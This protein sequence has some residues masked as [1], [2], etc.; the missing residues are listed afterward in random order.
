MTVQSTPQLSPALFVSELAAQDATW[1]LGAQTWQRATDAQTGGALGLI[2][3]VIAPGFASPY[4]VHHKEDESF[5]V[6]EGTMRFYSEGCAWDAGAGGFAFLPRDIPHGFRVMGDTPARVLLLMTPGGFE[7]FVA[8]LSEPSP[9]AGPPDMGHLMRVAEK[10]G[11]DI[12]GP[13]PE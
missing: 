2:E 5:Y 1:F 4:H 10:Y 9:P 8:E 11:I 13:L 7:G 6:L 3:Q 12:L